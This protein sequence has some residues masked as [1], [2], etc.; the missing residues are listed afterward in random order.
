MDIINSSHRDED[1]GI[2]YDHYARELRIH[3]AL[4]DTY[5]YRLNN[6][7]SDRKVLHAGV[8]DLAAESHRTTQE[9][10]LLRERVTQLEIVLT[11]VIAVWVASLFFPLVSVLIGLAAAG[12]WLICWPWILAGLSWCRS[13]AQVWIAEPLREMM[14]WYHLEKQGDR[15]ECK[16]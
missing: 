4:L 12:L 2:I 1:D 15:D 3:N 5:G 9:I 16:G 13:W 6:A 8:L 7:D 14:D 11:G 10:V